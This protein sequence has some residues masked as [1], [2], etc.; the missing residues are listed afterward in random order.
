MSLEEE[1]VELNSMI[2]DMEYN[3]ELCAEKSPL[4]RNKNVYSLLSPILDKSE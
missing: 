4:G 3:V 2:N 1:R